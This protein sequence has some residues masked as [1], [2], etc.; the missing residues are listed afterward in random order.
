MA[1]SGNTNFELDRN[2]I[3]ESA[4]RKI[5]RLALGQT[6][7]AEEYTSAGQ[8]L[9]SLVSLYSTE[10]MP[11]WKRTT[12]TTTLVDGT[13]SY[14]TNNIIKVAQVILQSTTSDV[15]YEITEK[16]LY[17]FN[18]LP[19]S[20]GSLPVHYTF[21][22]GISSG[23]ITV[24]PTPDATAAAEYTL[25]AVYQRRFDGFF[26]ASDTP[27]FPNY[28]TDALIY[29]LAVR[30]APEYGVP[31]QDRQ[32]LLKEAEMYKKMASDYGDEDGSIFFQPDRGC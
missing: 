22:P 23:T 27:D 4:L 19:T 12:V 6:P 9:N 26:G 14:T 3:I 17:D 20:D 1:T 2:D 10:G 18:Q 31:L 32:L 28:W 13:A 30:L 7:E 8:A 15:Q 29:G 24:W 25:I 21:A 5:G 11:L 16:S